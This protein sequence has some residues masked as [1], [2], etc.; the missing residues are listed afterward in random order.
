MSGTAIAIAFF[1]L[2]PAFAAIPMLAPTTQREQP[3]QCQS[4]SVIGTHGSGLFDHVSMG[5]DPGGKTGDTVTPTTTSTSQPS[6]DG[7][8]GS[9]QSGANS[10]APSGAANTKA[11]PSARPA[12]GSETSKQ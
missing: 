1:S 6:T 4:A 12:S 10:T 8:G 2:S 11:D 3:E 9:S 5:P 7:A